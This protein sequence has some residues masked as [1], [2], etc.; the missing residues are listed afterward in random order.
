M[1]KSLLSAFFSV[2]AALSLTAADKELAAVT[3]IPLSRDG[4]TVDF[5]KEYSLKTR[6]YFLDENFE[7][8]KDKAALTAQLQEKRGP[9]FSFLDGTFPDSLAAADFLYIGQ[10]SSGLSK[11]SNYGSLAV[12][13]RF[14]D[15]LR[16]FLSNGGMIYF[17]Y[18]SLRPEMNS[19]FESVGVANP[20]SNWKAQ[21][22][23]QYD[24]AVNPK[25]KDTPP[26]NYP[27]SI[28]FSG[29]GWVWENFPETQEALI[30]AKDDPGKAGMLIQKNVCGAGVIIFNN[31]AMIFRDKHGNKPFRENILS[32]AFK[33]NIKDYK[34][35]K[36]KESGGPG[37]D[38]QL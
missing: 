2:C 38:V 33:Q 6:C 29:R 31:A 16:K 32:M 9:S 35:K 36:D 30:T 5:E 25:H 22:T 4:L 34:R 12:I 8:S 17:D 18:Q 19:F 13:T 26:L 21:K 27:N 14:Q 7:Q 24:Y 37:A 11:K 20:Y 1:K 15:A 23:E 28:N 10:F 3:V